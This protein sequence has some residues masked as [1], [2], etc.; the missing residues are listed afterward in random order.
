MSE[1][2][3]GRFVVNRLGYGA[4][5]L[6]G[7]GV[8]GPPSDPAEAIA[9]LRSAVGT[10]VNHID[11]AQYYGPDVVNDLIREALYPYGPVL[12]SLARLASVGTGA[13]GSSCTTNPTTYGRASR[14]T[15]PASGSSSSPPSTSG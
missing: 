15:W 5:R 1:F 14:T 7:P 12:P 4:M 3:L 13:V 11:T 8:F 9:L 10:G 6:A 2:S